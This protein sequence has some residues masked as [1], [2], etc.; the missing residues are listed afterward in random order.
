VGENGVTAVLNSEE[1]DNICPSDASSWS[2]VDGSQDCSISLICGSETVPDDSV[3]NSAGDGNNIPSENSL[4]TSVSATPSDCSCG[5]NLELSS[6]C[7]GATVQSNSIGEYAKVCVQDDDTQVYQHTT[8]NFYLYYESTLQKWLISSGIAATSANIGISSSQSCAYEHSSL[9]T[10]WNFYDGSNYVADCSMDLVCK[11]NRRKRK[12]RKAR[13][14]RT[15]FFAYPGESIDYEESEE[16]SISDNKIHEQFQASR[17]GTNFESIEEPNENNEAESNNDKKQKRKRRTRFFAYPSSSVIK[18]R[19][20]AIAKAAKHN[21][22]HRKHRINR[23]G[24]CSSGYTVT[25]D[26]TGSSYQPDTAGDY[27]EVCSDDGKPIFRKSSNGYYLYVVENSGNM[28]WTISNRVGSTTFLVM[29]VAPT[30]AACPDG[31]V[32][33]I[34]RTGSG[35]SDYVVT[36]GI[37][38]AAT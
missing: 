26:S 17:N 24:G 8:E 12:K 32:A 14:K 19:N 4:P 23:T 1:T 13:S 10:K 15:R 21:K 6:S 18:D 38:I 11:S 5:N 28:Y 22:K 36:T 20:L 3:T 27:E 35:S 34:V 33:H 31:N 25:L 7:L 16:N 2:Y 37:S 30:N 29:G 9:D